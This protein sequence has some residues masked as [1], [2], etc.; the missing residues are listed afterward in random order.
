MRGS[1]SGGGDRGG[2]GGKVVWREATG[3]ETVG[4]VG[5]EGVRDGDGSEGKGR[6]RRGGGGG[7]G[8][9][10]TSGEVTGVVEVGVGKVGQGEVMG[11]Q[12]G[13]R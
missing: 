9:E 8:G 13:G 4:K 12:R 6:P 1:G 7:S 2:S 11:W 5:R 10:G 3:V